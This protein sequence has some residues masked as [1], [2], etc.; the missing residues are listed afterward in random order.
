M[1]P[2]TSLAK[3]L[4]KAYCLPL[5]LLLC[6]SFNQQVIFFA[7]GLWDPLCGS[8]F[9]LPGRKCYLFLGY[10]RIAPDSVLPEIVTTPVV[11]EIVLVRRPARTGPE[12]GFEWSIEG[13]LY[14]EQPLLGLDRCTW[15]PP[16]ERRRVFWVCLYVPNICPGVHVFLT[17]I[18]DAAC[19]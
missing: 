7:A 18:R 14:T 16:R 12:A 19:S 5:C 4:P 8:M 13:N 9:D 11:G 3:A 1:Y 10:E 2:T 6:L 15:L 17:G